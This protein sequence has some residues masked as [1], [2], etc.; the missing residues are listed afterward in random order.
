MLKTIDSILNGITMYRLVVYYLILLLFVGLIFS[1]LGILAFNPFALLFSV[2]FLLAAGVITNKIFGYVFG[3]QANVESVYI[4]ALILAL[5]I[6]PVRSL[7]DFAFLFWAAVLTMASKFILA[8][9]KKHIFNPVALAVA[10]TALTG[11]GSATW[12]VGS[13]PMLPFVILGVFVIFKVRRFD[14]LFYFFIAYIAGVFILDIL[15]GTSLVNTLTRA[16]TD[17][18]LFFFAAIMLTEPITTPPTKSLQSI[19]GALV[20]LLMVPKFN[21]F[22]FYLTPELALLG[23]NVFSYLVSP[24]FR[25]VLKLKEKIKLSD[26]LYDFVFAGEKVNFI[27]G[28][29]MEWTLSHPNTD[30]R[31]NRRYFT[32]ASSPTE[33]DIRLGVKFFPNS[34]SYKKALLAMKVGDEITAG[35][36]MGDFTLPKD[37]N[38]KLAFIAGGIGITPFRSIIKYLSDKG[39]KRDIVLLYTGKDLAEMAYFAVFSEAAKKIGL[40]AFYT[41]T[42]E[43]KIPANWAGGRGRFSAETI[44]KLIPDYAER[45]FYV[46]GSNRMVKGFEDTLANMRLKSSQT[47]TDFFPGLM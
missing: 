31:G 35:A 47:V 34:S 1:T 3:V 21:I 20:G 15:S 14:M 8:I 27:P 13:L 46:S 26:N 9:N 36:L 25:L 2:G 23:G 6:S 22:G 4:S 38:K 18:P 12:W 39:E 42:D 11:I 17:T 32:L 7:H 37:P 41:L 5:I 40:K 10:L 28:Q 43:T 16:A 19:Y 33:E 45:T 44:S 29:F 30:S 24:K